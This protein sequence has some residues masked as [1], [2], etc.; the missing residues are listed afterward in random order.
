[1]PTPDDRPNPSTIADAKDAI[2][3]API[4]SST[5]CANGGH[6]CAHP[7]LRI[8]TIG[9]CKTRAT[10]LSHVYAIASWPIS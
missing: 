5:S 10:N 6:R 3:P 7:T 9:G 1:M 4:S 2:D 8:S